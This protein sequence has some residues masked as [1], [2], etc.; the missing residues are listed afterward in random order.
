M[1]E[2]FDLT[3]VG[4]GK[5]ARFTNERGVVLELA[6]PQVGLELTLDLSGMQI[7]LR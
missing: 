5:V 4:G 1:S 3:V 6:G 7:A 2:G